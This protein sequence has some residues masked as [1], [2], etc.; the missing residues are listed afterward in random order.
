MTLASK[1]GRGYDNV[2]IRVISDGDGI[3][4]ALYC[5]DGQTT[6]LLRRW[7]SKTNFVA[8]R[9]LRKMTAGRTLILRDHWVEDADIHICGF[10]PD[11]FKL[12]RRDDEGLLLQMQALDAFDH[13]ELPSAA[14]NTSSFPPCHTQL[15]EVYDTPLPIRVVSCGDG[16][17]D[18]V[19]CHDG[20][21]VFLLRQWRT[22][23]ALRGLRD[24]RPGETFELRQH[25]ISRGG[26]IQIRGD[27]PPS[28]KSTQE[29]DE[30][31]GTAIGSRVEVAPLQLGAYRHR[32]LLSS[33]PL[34]FYQR[35]CPYMGGWQDKMGR[36]FSLPVTH[37]LLLTVLFSIWTEPPAY[38]LQRMW[39]GLVCSVRSNI[40]RSTP[41][42]L[43]MGRNPAWLAQSVTA[44]R[45]QCNGRQS[46]EI[47]VLTHAIRLGIVDVVVALIPKV[48]HDSLHR[49]GC[50]A[51][52]RYTN[53]MHWTTVLL[54]RD[55][56]LFHETWSPR[57]V[58]RIIN[59]AVTM[60]DEGVLLIA[61]LISRGILELDVQLD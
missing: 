9:P 50:R 48:F 31:D 60:G 11:E 13:Y 16:E 53:E 5:H 36:R 37:A 52:R 21:R 28:C 56:G 2:L 34:T 32:V 51:C 19:F 42:W 18:A 57:I 26:E 20:R 17:E 4:E 29:L 15:D 8:Q 24:V 54:A 7:A 3:E 6:F 46:C 58:N 30:Y 61:M 1:L 39:R 40:P 10:I 12:G 59:T 25:W 45:D 43:D 55:K 47:G 44:T 38:F 49:G 14:L 27:L 23:G 22:N 35:V 33:M 41:C